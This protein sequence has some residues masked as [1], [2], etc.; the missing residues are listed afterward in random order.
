MMS[1]SSPSN[2]VA[3]AD[4]VVDYNAVEKVGTVV[5]TK[6]GIEISQSL[7]RETDNRNPQVFGLKSSSPD[8]IASG[9]LEVIENHLRAIL[10]AYKNANKKKSPQSAWKPVYAHCEALTLYLQSRSAWFESM[11]P[12]EAERVAR[13]FT[14]FGCAWV[15]LADKLNELG[16]FSENNYPSVRSAVNATITVGNEVNEKVGKKM[17][18]WPAKLEAI[19]TGNEYAGDKKKKQQKPED[20]DASGGSKKKSKKKSQDDDEDD[21]A[22]AGGKKKKGGKKPAAP[23][24]EALPAN[25]WDF[26]DSIARL[27]ADRKQIGGSLFDIAVMSEE[28][29]LKLAVA[30]N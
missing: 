14:A 27:K 8:F 11:D 6:C 20:G 30:A 2:A 12:K 10:K 26:E 13:A 19:W 1:V 5:W 25:P 17:S 7:M 16:S 22:G 9:E 24:D 23:V 3:S 4:P 21:D 29:R 28:M 15:C 18:D